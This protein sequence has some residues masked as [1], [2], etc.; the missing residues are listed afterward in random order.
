MADRQS[1]GRERNAAVPE[2]EVLKKNGG[3]VAED[4]SWKS[5]SG[6]DRIPG[7]DGGRPEE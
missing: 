4:A 7:K 1:E 2:S 5:E 3:K 6:K